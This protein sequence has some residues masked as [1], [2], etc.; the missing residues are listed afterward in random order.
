[1]KLAFVLP[2]FGENVPGGAELVARRFAENLVQSDH[3]VEVL[4]TCIRDFH[5]DWSKN[6]HREGT[7]MLNGVLVRR[8][9]V[10]RRDQHVFDDLNA[11]LLHGFNLTDDEERRFMREMIRSPRLNKFIAAHCSE[12]DALFFIPYLFSTSYYGVQAC[13]ERAWLIPTLHDEG[14]AYMQLIKEMFESVYGVIFVSQPEMALARHLYDLGGTRISMIGVGVNAG[15]SGNAERFRERAGVSDPFVLYIGR[16]DIT[17]NVPLLIQYFRRYQALRNHALKLILIGSGDIG[18][19]AE[20]S[21]II[22][23]GFVS[24]EIKADALAAA[25]VL[26]QPSLNESFSR[27]VMEA[28]LASVPVMVHADCAVTVDHCQRSNGGLF[29]RDFAEFASSLDFLL[30]DP[31]TAR[32]MG[33]LGGQYVR[34]NFQWD[35][36]I[37]RLNYVLQ[38]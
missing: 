20:S 11:R 3:V 18:D 8:F 29:F 2:W 16:R 31:D 35:A 14:Y 6:H 13:P 24:S 5:A 28:W 33:Q 17:K 36:V 12:Y 26:C 10:S 1:M 32:R 22:D 30:S 4:T 19:A 21:D 27:V 9:K 38:H 7:S 25:S 34:K 23:L 37:K 15:V